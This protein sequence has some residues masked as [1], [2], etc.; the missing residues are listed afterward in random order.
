MRHRGSAVAAGL[1]RSGLLRRAGVVAATLLAAVAMVASPLVTPTAA[2]ANPASDF[3]PGHIISD[4]NFYDGSAMT[5]AKIQKFLDERVPRCTIGD[6]GRKPGSKYKTTKVATHCLKNARFTTSSRPANAYCK[7]YTG[8][9][10]ETAAKIIGKVGRACGISPKVL[11]VMLEKEQSLVTDTWP[12]QRQ[13]DFAMGY[14]CP[15]SGPNNTANCSSSAGGFPSQ[16]YRGAWQLKVYKAKPENYNYRPFQ[17]NTIQWNPNA[18]CGTSRVYIENWATAALYIYTP[19]RPNQAALNA[20]W[21]SGNSCS[22]YGNRN[23]YNFY[24]TWFGS[25]RS[26]FP[27]HSKLKK[28]YG[29]NKSAVGKPTAKA[30]STN[31]VVRQQFAQARMYWKKQAGASIVRG[32][33]L[34]EYKKQKET[35]GVLGAP[36]GKQRTVLNA[37]NQRFEKGEIFWSQATGALLV[38]GDVYKHYSAKG[39]SKTFGVPKG[40]QTGTAATGVTQDFSKKRLITWSAKSGAK[41]VKGEIRQRYLGSGGVTALGY[42]LSTESKVAGG[43]QQRFSKATIFR[44]KSYGAQVVKGEILKTLNAKGG[45]AKIGMPKGAQFKTSNGG[46]RQNFAKKAIVWTKS[47]GG[48]VVSLS[49]ASAVAPTEPTEPTEQP[50]AEEQPNEQPP[51]EDPSTEQPTESEEPTEDPA[52]ED[53]D[54]VVEQPDDGADAP[55]EG[56]Q[57]P[58]RE[59]QGGAA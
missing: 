27:V 56:A 48:K 41:T 40:N 47:G 35:S 44:S 43:S 58:A 22:S 19:Y 50:P 33:I 26:G 11:L 42:A 13:F 21:G 59:E 4:A 18:S 32:N 3:Q 6:A 31:G 8:G 14:D 12:T 29:A 25:P 46:L 9:K 30:S 49:K 36:I 34:A 37:Q 53:P 23:F 51:V 28:Y 20:G 57:A 45:V 52:A 16:V 2:H 17:T 24:K 7:A 55:N 5:T 10:N 1:G 38:R 39:S 54:P 15:D